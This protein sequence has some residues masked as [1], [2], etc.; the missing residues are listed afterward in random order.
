MISQQ[1]IIDSHAL[2]ATTFKEFR[3][4]L[5]DA[6]GHTDHNRKT[7]NTVVTDFD[8]DI[9]TTLKKRLLQQFPEFGFRGEETDAVAGTNH[10][11]WYV[12]PIDSTLSFIHGLPYCTNMAGLV[13]NGEIVASLIYDF[14]TDELFT[15]FKGRG[16]YR[17]GERIRVTNAELSDSCVFADAYSYK[18]AYSFFAPHDVKFYAPV[19]ASGYFFTRLAQGSIQG[20][21]Y[22]N[23]NIKQHDVIPGA[24]LVLEAG[25]EAVS[26][27][28]QPFDYQC[29]RFML[30]S[31]NISGLATQYAAQL[32]SSAA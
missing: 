23:A 19:G 13:V 18:N 20:V 5:L 2:I 31:K 8:V 16:A 28:E 10:A 1:Q 3:S 17:N 29:Q 32:K 25:G 21:C 24:L 27:T 12:D 11:T 6:Y 26:F 7:D 15:A 9:E 22:L 14:I 30:G 4:A